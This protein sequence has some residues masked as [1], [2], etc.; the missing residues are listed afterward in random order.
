MANHS[1]PTCWCPMVPTGRGYDQKSNDT[2]RMD[3][4]FDWATIWPMKAINH[5]TLNEFS[6]RCRAKTTCSLWQ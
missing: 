2:S 1:T 3:L 4:H 6:K 5:P